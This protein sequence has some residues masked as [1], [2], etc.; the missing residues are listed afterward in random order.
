VPTDRLPTHATVRVPVVNRTLTHVAKD[1]GWQEGWIIGWREAFLEG[2]REG[3]RSALLELL[4]ALIDTQFGPPA[5]E[6]LAKLREMPV[7]QLKRL[8]VA[9]PKAKTLADLGL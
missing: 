5:A 1:V 4:E 2:F 7:E 8:A 3:R 6:T 9:L